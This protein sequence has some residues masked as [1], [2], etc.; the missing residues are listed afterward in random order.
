MTPAD[1][2]Y[3][4]ATVSAMVRRIGG[5]EGVPVVAFD[6]VEAFVARLPDAAVQEIVGA[7][8]LLQPEQAFT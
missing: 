8:A 6:R 7:F 4:R 5:E 2:S 3:D 1:Y